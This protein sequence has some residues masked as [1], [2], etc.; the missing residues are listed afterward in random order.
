MIRLKE[1]KLTPT[2][3]T[4]DA[5]IVGDRYNHN[6]ITKEDRVILSKMFNKRYGGGFEYWHEN[7]GEVNEV[8]TA[9]G[10]NGAE[11]GD[12]KRIVMVIN[13]C[14]KVLVHETIHVLWYL[15]RESGLDMDFNSQ[16]WQACMG[17]YIFTEIKDFKK[18]KQPKDQDLPI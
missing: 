11:I 4:L 5:Y 13:P 12:T 18:L 6:R 16:E 1:V 8:F 7:T 15:S 10:K 9:H 14:I 3:F 2:Q 17:E